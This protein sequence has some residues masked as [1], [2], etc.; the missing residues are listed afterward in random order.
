MFDWAIAAP[1]NLHNLFT[2]LV[3]RELSRG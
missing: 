1:G 3:Y 2:N